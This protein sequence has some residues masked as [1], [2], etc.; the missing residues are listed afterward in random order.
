MLSCF[1]DYGLNIPL[2]WIPLLLSIW[3]FATIARTRHRLRRNHCPAC[4]YDM[5]AAS[6]P[7]CSECGYSTAPATKE[8]AM[9]T[10]SPKPIRSRLVGLGL[11]A[12]A[13]V[14]AAYLL[15][16]DARPAFPRFDM[17]ASGDRLFLLD[18]QTGIVRVFR[19]DKEIR[20]FDAP[21]ALDEEGIWVDGFENPF[22]DL[23]NDDT[24]SAEVTSDGWGDDW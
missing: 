16:T 23:D 2:V 19:G 5:R 24:D 13:I 22:P 15:R 20:R 17:T 8:T 9:P 14:S 11:L 1:D 4:N 6:R 21:L 3:P 10:A 7:R 18:Q 12:V